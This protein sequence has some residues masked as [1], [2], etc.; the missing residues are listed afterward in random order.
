[1]EKGQE[2]IYI[3]CDDGQ[4]NGGNNDDPRSCLIEDR[5]YKIAYVEEHSWHTKIGL[6][7]FPGKLFNSVCFEE[8]D[9]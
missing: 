7:E 2:V 9:S 6:C 1:M 4:V 3:G 8:V 5:I